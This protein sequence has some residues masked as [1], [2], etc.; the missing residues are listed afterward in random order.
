MI[1]KRLTAAP[2]AC[3]ATEFPNG[4]IH[5]GESIFQQTGVNRRPDV[6]VQDPTTLEVLKVYEAARQKA[7]G[8]FVTREQAKM[9]EYDAAGI[10]YHFEPVEPICG[11]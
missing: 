5:E 2:E 9:S 11:R 4:I 7:D 8:T 10:P 1:G 3:A 6:W